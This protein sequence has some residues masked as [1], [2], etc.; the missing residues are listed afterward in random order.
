MQLRKNEITA[1]RED[2]YK[3]RAAFS[4]IETEVKET[5]KQ[6]GDLKERLSNS[7]MENQRLRGYVA[8][9]QEDDAVREELITVGD[10]DGERRLIP[11]R[12]STAFVE[13]SQY[14]TFGSDSGNSYLDQIRDRGAKPKHWINY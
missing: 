9:V 14:G 1:L 13:P 6:F 4:A 12:K 10:P 3:A 5:R 11:K 7:E 8:R 2:L